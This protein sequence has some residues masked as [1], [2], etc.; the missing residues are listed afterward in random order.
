MTYNP[1]HERAYLSAVKAKPTILAELKVDPAWFSPKHRK[2]L[3]V[4]IGIIDS[5]EQP[6]DL[7]L[8]D[9]GIEVSLAVSFD[10]PTTG[11]AEYYHRSLRS[12]GLTR[13]IAALGEAIPGYLESSETPEQAL[14]MIESTLASI[15]GI[16]ADRIIH[17]QKMIPGAVEEIERLHK[18]GGE[19]SGI[20]SG[21][22][23]IDKLLQGFRPGQL[24]IIGARPSIGKTSMALSMGIRMA[25]SGVSIGFVSLEMSIEELSARIIAMEASLNLKSIQCGVMHN[26]DFASITD[27]GDRL[28]MTD[29]WFDDS[30]EGTLANVKGSIRIMASRGARCVF[31]DYLGLIDNSSQGT[32]MYE[33]M[34]E[35]ARILKILARKLGIPI[36]L[37]CQLN[38]LAEGK[39]PTMANLA[40]SGKIEQHAD[41]VFL[42][43]RAARDDPE[44]LGIISKA[45]NA[46]TGTVHLTFLGAFTRYEEAAGVR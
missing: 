40:E 35:V 21:F 17:I 26:R 32:S 25:K 29:A 18:L 27:A 2:V 37:L 7:R 45:R 11:N 30:P 34:G 22:H 3:E 13:Q 28:S 44:A 14:D 4:M 6:N 20:T 15:T 12:L 39:V 16:G 23:S 41:I 42:L 10:L 19:L 33:S 31:V 46:E 5:G 38:R 9:A 8:F 1:E 36:I 43:H 24:V